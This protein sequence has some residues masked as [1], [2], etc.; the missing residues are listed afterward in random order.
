LLSVLLGLGVVLA[1]F[2]IVLALFPQEPWIAVTTSALVAFIPQHLA[3]L[4]GVNNDALAEFVAALTLL[5]LVRY[6][7]AQQVTWR[8]CARLG[9]LVGVALLTK[10]TIYFLA[11]VV[12]LAIL[13]R[14]WREGTI[15]PSL[16]AFLIPA[17]LLGGVWWGRNLAVYGRTD[18]L[19]LQAHDEVAAGQLQTDDYLQNTLLGD[20]GE[21][22]RNMA[23]TAFHS[24]WGQFGW[25]A[26]PMETRVYRLLLLVCGLMLLGSGLYAWQVGFTRPQRE[27]M[28]FLG[29][30]IL[31][32][33]SA[34]LYYNLKFV[35]FQGRYL[36]PALIPLALW[37]ALG[38]TG[39]AGFASRWWPPLRWGGVWLALLLAGLAW[40]ALTRYLVPNLPD[41]GV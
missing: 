12:G 3:I 6:W 16:A 18:F 26:V 15:G 1:S 38:L 2:A 41:W 8:A 13:W 33:A 36:Y 37:G 22:W 23:Y 20:R 19:G 14:A 17:L 35:Q 32:V 34:F 24:F 5:A 40:L 25:M 27:Y 28:A 39:W 7:Q 10:S 31:F 21:Y 29:L 9:L 11:G 4:S 30:T